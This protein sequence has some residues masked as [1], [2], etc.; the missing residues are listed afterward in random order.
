MTYRLAFYENGKF[1]S[2]IGPVYDRKDSALFALG[3]TYADLSTL[4]HV[5]AD[6]PDF[7]TYDRY[8][9]PCMIRIEEVCS[10]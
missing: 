2:Y 4:F 10:Q 8:G 5:N 6:G 3:E 7:L 9:T 1:S